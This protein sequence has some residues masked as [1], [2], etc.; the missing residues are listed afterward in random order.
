M[1]LIGRD[2]AHAPVALRP[3]PETWP[4]ASPACGERDGTSH[5]KEPSR[6]K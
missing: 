3:R 6:A 5:D 4:L 2:C 1:F